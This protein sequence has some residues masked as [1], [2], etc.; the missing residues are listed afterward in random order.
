VIDPPADQPPAGDAPA[1]LQQERHWFRRDR[2]TNGTRRNMAFAGLLNARLDYDAFLASFAALAERHEVLRTTLY[3][4]HGMVW[5]RVHPRSMVTREVIDL[6]GRPAG[7]ET[8]VDAA[9]TLRDREFDLAHGPLAASVLY[10]LTDTEHLFVLVCNHVVG[11]GWSLGIAL[12]ELNEFYRSHVD[13]RPPA[14]MPLPWQ[15]GDYARWQRGWLTGEQAEQYSRYWKG[16]LYGRPGKMLAS[17]QRPDAPAGAAPMDLDAELTSEVRVFARSA[18]TTVFVVLLTAYA[19]E[20]AARIGDDDVL[21]AIAVARRQQPRTHPLIGFFAGAVCLRLD[22]AGAPTFAEAVRRVHAACMAG[23]AREELDL[24]AYLRLVEPDRDED[25][26]PIA[27]AAFF[28]EP[29]LSGLALAGTELQPVDL[30]QPQVPSQLDAAVH[31]EGH[32]I[33]GSLHYAPGVLS[34]EE[35]A[36]FTARFRAIL[37]AGVRVA[38]QAAFASGWTPF[39]P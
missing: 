18:R 28:F 7:R 39:R 9:T 35:A 25:A 20:L 19:I 29:A 3:E 30:G 34:S 27:C 24:T 36:N 5:Q 26:D 23:V 2:T 22:L 16:L 15:Y 17:R 8:A 1:S 13:G 32:I 31:D 14:L 21:V 4:R 33:T 37:A 11:D 38:D 10:R 12:A 6:R